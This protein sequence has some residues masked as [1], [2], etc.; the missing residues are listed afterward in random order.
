[1]RAAFAFALI[2]SAGLA[3]LARAEDAAPMSSR[4][5]ASFS[6][7]PSL[8]GG[9]A[10]DAP[11]TWI[12]SGV[13]QDSHETFSGTLVTGKM[14]TQF[15]LRLAGGATCDGGDLTPA[16]GLVRLSEITCSDDRVMKALFVPQGGE[17]LKVFGHLGD[18]RFV[19]IAHLLGTE[20]PPETPQTAAPHAPAPAAP[21]PSVSRPAPG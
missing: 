13:L 9:Q 12:F 10:A 5:P 6:P 15:E 8:S 21:Q 17:A 1:M 7:D 11:D 16:T 2:V 3:T 18:E 20:P 19:T 14:D 4:P